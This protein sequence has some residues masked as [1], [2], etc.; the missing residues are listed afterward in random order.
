M[1]KRAE[2]KTPLGMMQPSKKAQGG[3]EDGRFGCKETSRGLDEG[4][5]C[6]RD[7]RRRT[8]VGWTP[9]QAGG[10]GNTRWVFTPQRNFDFPNPNTTTELTVTAEYSDLYV[11]GG[12]LNDP[13]SFGFAEGMIECVEI[14]L[15]SGAKSMS[16]H[17]P[18][19]M[20]EL[21]FQMFC[22]QHGWESQRAKQTAKL[23]WEAQKTLGHLARAELCAAEIKELLLAKM[24]RFKASSATFAQAAVIDAI[25][26]ID[27]PAISIE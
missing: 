11:T 18:T 15:T 17:V 10:G 3:K 16:S 22:S 19:V 21:S 20:P 12:E 1:G 25:V 24:F 4:S 6:R 8:E 14:P 7:K 23:P 27:L 2:G 13:N 26:L 5:R 9:G